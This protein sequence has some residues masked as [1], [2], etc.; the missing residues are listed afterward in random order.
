MQAFGAEL[1]GTCCGRRKGWG[2]PGFM[3]HSWLCSVQP[4]VWPAIGWGPAVG[5]S[6]LPV[7]W[8]V[9]RSKWNNT[10]TE[11]CLRKCLAHCF[12]TSRVRLNST[13]FLSPGEPGDHRGGTSLWKDRPPNLPCIYVK[14][15]LISVLSHTGGYH[16]AVKTPSMEVYQNQ[17]NQMRVGECNTEFSKTLHSFSLGIVSRTDLPAT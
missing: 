9:L 5:F 13:M 15:V 2:E 17:S 8:D 4:A 12:P 14:T 16:Q 11:C 7:N 6:V 1:V 3:S 10:S